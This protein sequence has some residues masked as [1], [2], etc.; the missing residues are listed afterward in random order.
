MPQTD[1]S[2]K[3]Q[4]VLFSSSKCSIISTLSVWQEGHRKLILG[5][6]FF[7]QKYFCSGI[8]LY[9]VLILYYKGEFYLA[10]YFLCGGVSPALDFGITSLDF[11]FAVAPNYLLCFGVGVD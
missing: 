7:V 8:H 6:S 4:S 5:G 10:S 11:K 1:D 9:F 2:F 3:G